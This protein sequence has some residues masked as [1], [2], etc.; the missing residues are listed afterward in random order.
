[1][2]LYMR[3]CGWVLLGLLIPELIAYT[4]FRQ[5]QQAKNIA[6]EMNSS[7][8]W[9][10]PS[11]TF[12]KDNDDSSLPQTEK[13]SKRR[14][15]FLCGWRLKQRQKDTEAF[16]FDSWTIAMVSWQSWEALR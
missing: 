12:A 16:S 8:E 3:K 14:S 6:R 11:P 2:R 15:R 1:M 7:E 5:H 10:C 9:G 4:A 13:K